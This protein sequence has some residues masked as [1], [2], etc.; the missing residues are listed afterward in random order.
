MNSVLHNAVCRA[1]P[2]VVRNLCRSPRR[3][4]NWLGSELSYLMG[5]RSE[6]VFRGGAR[7]M[8]NCKC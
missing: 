4:A 5:R 3:T 8:G 7:R 2:C 6:L 1:V